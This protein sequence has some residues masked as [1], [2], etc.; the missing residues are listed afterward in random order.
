MT[1]YRESTKSTLQRG[2][3]PI[4]LPYLNTVEHLGKDRFRFKYNGGEIETTLNSVSSIMLYGDYGKLEA[5]TLEAIVSKGVPIVIHHRNKT[6]PI[7][8]CTPLRPDQ[9]DTLSCQLAFRA[10]QKKVQHI[11]RMLLKAKFNSMRW[12]LADCPRLKPQMDLAQLRR[13]EALHAKR[14]WDLFYKRLGIY[15]KG[16]RTAGRVTAALD[17]ASKFLSGIILRWITYHHLS[18]FHGYLHST[19]EYPALVYDLIEPYR[20]YFDKVVFEKAASIAEPDENAGLIGLTI[21]GIKESLNEH[22]YTGLTR[23]IVT[24]HELLHGAVLSLKCY[25]QGRQKT[26][27]IPQV[28]KPTGGRPRRVNFRL[29]GRQAGRTDFWKVAKGISK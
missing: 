13:C 10:N 2:R 19:A 3:V 8:I 24:R 16:R 9:Q 1:K 29:Y 25:L 11:A 20:G 27:M 14:Y 12:L 21:E 4:W 26:F 5:A 23:Q 17:C 15:K 22:V 6:R 18:P 28:D 7:Y